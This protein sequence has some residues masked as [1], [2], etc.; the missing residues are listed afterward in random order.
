MRSGQKTRLLFVIC[1]GFASAT[2]LTAISACTTPPP[3]PAAS[4]NRPMTDAE[5]QQKVTLDAAD[6]REALAAMGSVPTGR[7]AVSR[8]R[9]AA[10]G[11][12]WSDVDNAVSYACNDVEMAV[13]RRMDVEGGFIYHIKTLDDRPG[14]LT[15]MRREDKRVYDATAV[16]GWFEDDT[17]KA[18]ALLDALKK[19]MRAFGRKRG[20]D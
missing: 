16:V 18:D 5:R 4:T 1:L 2:T 12:R 20:F 19:Q 6:R 10:D 8:P 14:R 13:T 15:I 3:P 9:P 7:K 17:P 11:V